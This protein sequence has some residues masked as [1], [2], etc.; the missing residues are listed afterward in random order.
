VTLDWVE[1]ACTRLLVPAPELV[2]LAAWLGAA[3]GDDT[4]VLV[5]RPSAVD[6]DFVLVL[7]VAGAV[8]S[9]T[10]GYAA[11][12]GPSVSEAERVLGGARE[13]ARP[14]TGPFQ[15]AFPGPSSPTAS[16]FIAGTTYD[17]PGLTAAERRLVE[18]TL[19]RDPPR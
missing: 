11:G 2:A 4:R 1:E 6:A 9:L 14:K 13:L 17:P 15:L 19:R 3:P 10:A 8:S 5:E 7:A 16:C 12:A 18:L